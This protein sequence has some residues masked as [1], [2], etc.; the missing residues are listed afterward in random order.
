M[1]RANRARARLEP[2]A[3]RRVRLNARNPSIASVRQREHVQRMAAR[4]RIDLRCDQVGNE[5]RAAAAEARRDGDV[6]LAAR[7]EADWEPLH[8]RREARSPQDA[9]AAHVNGLELT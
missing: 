6:L 7:P 1:I 5:A 4:R 8:G 9:P 3:N 2:A